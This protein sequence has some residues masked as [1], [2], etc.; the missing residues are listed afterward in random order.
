MCSHV[1]I[2][3]MDDLRRRPMTFSNPEFTQVG[4]DTDPLL[5]SHQT[6]NRADRQHGMLWVCMILTALLVAVAAALAIFSVIQVSSVDLNA[7]GKSTAFNVVP[8]APE[9]SDCFGNGGSEITLCRD[10]NADQMCTGA[11]SNI[12]VVTLCNGG[13]GTDGADGADG[14]DG[15][16]GEVGPVGPP[17]PPGPPSETQIFIA[18]NGTDPRLDGIIRIGKDFIFEGINVHVRDGSGDTPAPGTLSC[19]S[20][21]S[22]GFAGQNCT[23]D[24]DCGDI[25]GACVG[26]GNLIIGYNEKSSHSA[27][28]RVGSHVLVIGEDHTYTAQVGLVTGLSN[29]ISGAGATVSGGSDN[30]ASNM[31]T[32]VSG[33]NSNTAS[34]DR[35]SVSGGNLN[36]ASGFT[37]TVSGGQRNEASGPRAYVSG[38]DGNT[39]SGFRASVSGGTGNFASGEA[40]SVSGGDGNTASGLA[41]S[42]SGGQQNIAA[43]DFAS[44]SGGRAN[45]ATGNHA[46]NLG[47]DGSSANTNFE[48]TL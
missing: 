2:Y 9:S 29:T 14:A 44:V 4:A 33:G 15:T 37:A 28:E 10:E 36:I 25:V 6:R 1:K 21:L 13:N 18:G 20:V 34:G 3:S 48:S 8:I 43:G 22:S 35:T 24:A 19:D 45:T 11:D 30:T 31:C 23:S 16:D 27:G 38:G 17:G 39:A 46:S 47:E 42:I 12:Q 41:A 26:C 5:A 40:T 7:I 32:S